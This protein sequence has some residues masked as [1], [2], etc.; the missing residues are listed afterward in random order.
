MESRREPNKGALRQP[1]VPS[2]R[3]PL[4]AG[5]S[6]VRCGPDPRKRDTVLAAVKDA[7]RRLRRWP[8]RAILDCGCARRH[9][10]NAGRDEET[11]LGRTK[12]LIKRR[13]T[14]S[15]Q[16]H[17]SR[18]AA[19]LSLQSSMHR[20]CPQTLDIIIIKLVG[21]HP[22]PKCRPSARLN[23]RESEPVERPPHP[24]PLHSPSQT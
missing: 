3:P 20:I 2:F 18:R 10:A 11:A 17:Q 22:G 23:I 24:D 8:K 13:P 15:L 5:T 1:Q 4:R 9:W 7:S 12:K 16:P 21:Y 14:H 6:Q 19:T